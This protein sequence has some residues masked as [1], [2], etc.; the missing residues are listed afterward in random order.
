MLRGIIER[1]WMFIAFVAIIILL[2]IGAK[3]RI[4]RERTL[5]H[6]AKV[7]RRN[8]LRVE[9]DRRWKTRDEPAR[10]FTTAAEKNSS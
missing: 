7:N 6:R 3:L 8:Q 10:S 5:R 9:R 2:W 1:P 4:K